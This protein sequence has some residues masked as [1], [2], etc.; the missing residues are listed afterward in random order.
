MDSSAACFVNKEY[1][2]LKELASHHEMMLLNVE[3]SRKVPDTWQVRFILKIELGKRSR[4]VINTHRY[5][6]NF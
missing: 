6:F 2:I 1:F 4:I 5:I 3:V